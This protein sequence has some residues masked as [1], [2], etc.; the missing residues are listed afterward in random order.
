MQSIPLHFSQW[1]FYLLVIIGLGQPVLAKSPAVVVSIK[2]IHSLVAGVMQ[3]VNKP[4]LLIPAGQSPHAFSLRPSAM[5][6]LKSA[7]LIFWMGEDFETPL[8]QILE[9]ASRQARVIELLNQPGIQHLPVRK[10]GVWESRHE[11][12]S[13]SHEHHELDPH[14][15]LSPRNAES[16]VII[17]R[18]QL[19]TVDPEHS[20]RYRLNAQ[21]MLARLATLNLELR[22]TL[23]SIRSLPYM[24][25]HDAYQY[26]ERHYALNTVGSIVIS[27]ERQ[28]GARRIH[29]VHKKL[30]QHKVRCIFSEPQFKPKLISTLTEGTQVSTG[31][32]DPV[33]AELPEGPE[34]YFQLLRNLADNLVGCLGGEP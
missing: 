25:F 3:G 19:M 18:D 11:Q 20:E 33:G 8:A 28:P 2:P 27:P 24:V 32:L 10:G 9:N 13:G 12:Y 26:F 17:A 29:E 22:E 5:R 30:K 6:K 21:Q 31:L 1:V 23:S 14:V 16:I 15:W 7:Q 34:A 4:L